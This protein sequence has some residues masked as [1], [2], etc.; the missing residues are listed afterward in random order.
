[1]KG[2]GVRDATEL[3]GGIECAER[4]RGLVSSA[5]SCRDLNVGCDGLGWKPLVWKILDDSSVLS[6]LN[7]DFGTSSLVLCLLLNWDLWDGIHTMGG[8]GSCSATTIMG[9][10]LWESTFPSLVFESALLSL[11][12]SVEDRLKML[13]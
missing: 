1:M 2:V 12:C 9:E 3:G 6:L 10:S 5:G 8:I 13:A 4:G 7:L 11:F